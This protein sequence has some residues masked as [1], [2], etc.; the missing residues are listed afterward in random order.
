MS[1]DAGFLGSFDFFVLDN[2]FDEGK[3]EFVGCIF[4]GIAVNQRL[5]LSNLSEEKMIAVKS[6]IKTFMARNGFELQIN[7][8]S[9]ETLEKA[10][11]EPEKYEDLLV[12]IGGYSDYFVRQSPQMQRE[13][14]ARSY[15]DL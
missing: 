15:Q 4:G 12:R 14:I 13:L 2:G 8:V 1:L 11:Q 7:S 9:P 6:L 5:N 3:V 10:M